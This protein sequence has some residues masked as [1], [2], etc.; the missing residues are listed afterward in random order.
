VKGKGK[1]V[2]VLPL[3]EHHGMKAYWGSG[4]AAPPILWHRH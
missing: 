4:G 3:T 1:L 2:P